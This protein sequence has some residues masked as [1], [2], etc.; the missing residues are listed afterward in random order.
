MCQ[1]VNFCTLSILVQ[2][3]GIVKCNFYSFC[4]FLCI[5][6]HSFTFLCNTLFLWGLFF[7]G[8]GGGGWMR[9]CVGRGRQGQGEGWRCPEIRCSKKSAFLQYCIFFFLDISSLSSISLSSF[10]DVFNLS[11]KK[12]P[13]LKDILNLSLKKLPFLKDIL[14]L[15]A[16]KYAFLP[17][18]RYQT[19]SK[20]P[21]SQPHK[22]FTPTVSYSPDIF[23]RIY[24]MTV[25]L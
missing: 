11:L 13:P 15:S 3:R 10:K 17:K 25:F 20:Y 4:V 16:K 18:Y 22:Q 8:M 1:D 21:D 2:G 6:I 9:R 14:N 24:K 7:C 19:F 5:I 12:L 23:S